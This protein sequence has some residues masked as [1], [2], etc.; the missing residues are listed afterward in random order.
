MARAHR[1]DLYLALGITIAVV[2]AFWWWQSRAPLL[3]ARNATVVVGAAPVAAKIDH[4]AA[5]LQPTAL[6]TEAWLLGTWSERDN[7]GD[8]TAACDL[9]SAITYLAD[10]RY[11]S[12]AASGRYALGG[13]SL[14]LWG[15]VIFDM[16]AGADRSHVGERSTLP[17]AR[18]DDDAMRVGGVV[19]Y[20]CDKA[21]NDHMEQ[22][23]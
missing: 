19:L 12:P 4:A 16:E 11:L 22:G 14:S 9:P 10:G 17:V 13:G 18:L 5:A 8:R 23:R 1:L 7:G 6:P 2:M 21:T 15:R 3:P 20:R